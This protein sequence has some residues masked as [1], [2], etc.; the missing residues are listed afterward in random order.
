MNITDEQ[1]VYAVGLKNISCPFPCA[2]YDE[3]GNYAAINKPYE[4]ILGLKSELAI[5]AKNSEIQCNF[6]DFAAVIDVQNKHVLESK[7]YIFSLNIIRLESGCKAYYVSKRPIINADGKVVGIDVSMYNTGFIFTL[8]S[9]FNDPTTYY[10]QGHEVDFKASRLCESFTPLQETYAYFIMCGF[11][12]DF[13]STVLGKS[14]KTVENNMARLIDK[15]QLRYSMKINSRKT[16]RYYLLQNRITNLSPAGLM[17]NTIKT[18]TKVPSNC[19]FNDTYPS[20]FD[21]I[22]ND[23][24]K[25]I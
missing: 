8:S 12:N 25:D 6:S 24:G 15:A 4:D 3:K 21:L 19:T 1:Y 11:S 2:I 9:A 17:A 23:F 20:E 22:F 16:L 14:I 7:D 5:G 13:I 10:N 18:L